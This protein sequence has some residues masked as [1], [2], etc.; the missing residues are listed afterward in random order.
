MGQPT[1]GVIS[2]CGCGGVYLRS[3]QLHHFEALFI[4]RPLQK[5]KAYERLGD[6]G[7]SVDINKVTAMVESMSCIIKPFALRNVLD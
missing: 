7:Y 3:R 1:P 2:S 6:K 5:L 4:A